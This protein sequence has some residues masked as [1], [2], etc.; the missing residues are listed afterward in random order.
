LC[1]MNWIL[2]I[3]V[4]V[5]KY[6]VERRGWLWGIILIFFGISVY[7]ALRPREVVYPENPFSDEY[8]RSQKYLLYASMQAPPDFSKIKGGLLCSHIAIVTEQDFPKFT[9]KLRQEFLEAISNDFFFHSFV[10]GG[11]NVRDIDEPLLKASRRLRMYGRPHIEIVIV[12]PSTI[13]S[14]TE[15][16][17]KEKG[18]IIRRIGNNLLNNSHNSD[19]ER[20]S[21]W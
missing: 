21:G 10:V 14:D 7:F 12:A 19:M 2:Y 20:P 11:M 8:R 13:A 4:G 1:E 17:L 3:F 15:W 6:I 5:L 9:K 18:F 16:I